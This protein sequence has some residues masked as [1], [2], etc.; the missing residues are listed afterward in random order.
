MD[1]PERRARGIALVLFGP[2]FGALLGPFVFVPLFAA[3]GAQGGQLMAP[4]L[5]A[6]GFMAVGLVL[7]LNVRP[8]PKRIGAMLAEQSG[9]WIIR[10]P[11]INCTSA[12]ETRVVASCEHTRAGAP[13]QEGQ[14]SRGTLSSADRMAA[15]R[16]Q[17]Y[18]GGVRGHRL[19]PRLGAP[20]TPPLQRA[21]SRGPR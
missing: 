16:A 21:G 14:R 1:P 12:K 10:N 17:D 18:R 13:L 4:W 20:D 8:D 9:A 5:G 11:V 15:Q 3:E 6:A 19:Q 2:V 7:I